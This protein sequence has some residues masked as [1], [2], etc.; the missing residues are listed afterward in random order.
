MLA[1]LVAGA[2]CDLDA[3]AAAEQDGNLAFSSHY[4]VFIIHKTVHSR[5]EMLAGY[6]EIREGSDRWQK[7]ATKLSHYS[8][9]LGQFASACRMNPSV[10]FSHRY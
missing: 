5:S 10:F 6:Y 3:T 8:R 4:G 2:F 1:V 7:S 9:T